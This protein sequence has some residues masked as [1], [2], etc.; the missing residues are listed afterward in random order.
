MTELKEL[1][2]LG[3]LFFQV[4]DVTNANFTAYF[5]GRTKGT[6]GLEMHSTF[7]PLSEQAQAVVRELV[8]EIV[9]ETLVVLLQLLD[10]RILLDGD[11]D[12]LIKTESGEMVSAYDFTE[13][14]GSEY[15]FNDGWASRLGK[16]AKQ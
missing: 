16:S 10:K 15:E 11:F 14:L 4:K 2:N 1:D 6:R 8:P 3:R 12:L 13:S 7:A 5:D 9:N